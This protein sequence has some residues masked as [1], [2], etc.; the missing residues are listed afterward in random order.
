MSYFSC[1]ALFK[2]PTEKK[3][4]K[5]FQES[6]EIKQAKKRFHTSL[7]VMFRLFSWIM[8]D[9]THLAFFVARLL[10]RF[11]FSLLLLL[12]VAFTVI[13]YNHTCLMIAQ[14]SN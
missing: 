3:Q 5:N 12:N 11:K 2:K 4:R 13:I 8:A 10:Q 1:F 6:L 7:T 14:S 9:F